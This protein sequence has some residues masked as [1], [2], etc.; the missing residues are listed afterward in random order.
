M[1]GNERLKIQRIQGYQTECQ[2]QFSC[3]SVTG[4]T[5]PPSMW[6]CPS[7]GICTRTENH[8]WTWAR[9]TN[10]A[11]LL[12]PRVNHPLSHLNTLGDPATQKFNSHVHSEGL[13][14]CFMRSVDRRRQRDTHLVARIMQWSI[15]LSRVPCTGEENIPPFRKRDHFI[16]GRTILPTSSQPVSFIRALS[17][18]A[19][20]SNTCTCCIPLGLAAM[21]IK[22]PVA[23]YV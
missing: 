7:I 1:H 12:L 3:V 21:V 22:C 8:P 18:I 6:F 15:V 4:E 19:S 2:M 10:C 5:K 16:N 14:G 17:V 11:N 13:V 9:E 20:I 23:S